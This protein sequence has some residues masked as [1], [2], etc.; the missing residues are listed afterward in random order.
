MQFSKLAKKLTK[1]MERA[2]IAV[3]YIVF[4]NFITASPRL[5]TQCVDNSKSLHF[6]YLMYL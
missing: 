4:L 5:S 6:K 2:L 1:F 3:T